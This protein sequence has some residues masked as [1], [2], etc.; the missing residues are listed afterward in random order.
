MK[1][2]RDDYSFDYEDSM[3][4]ATC[5][6]CGI[7]AIGALPHAPNSAGEGHAMDG[8]VHADVCALVKASEQ[9]AN[10]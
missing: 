8:V 5:R 2:T 6:H 10:K 7:T 1:Y 9:S 3:T 4:S